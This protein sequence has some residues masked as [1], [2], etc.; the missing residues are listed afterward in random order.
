MLASN[1]TFFNSTDFYLKVYELSPAKVV[2]VLTS[3]FIIFILTPLFYAIIWYEQYSSNH[4][5][6]LIN[7]LVASS[8]WHTIAYNTIGQ[9][10]EVVLSLFGPFNRVFCNVQMVLKNISNLQ[11]INLLLAMTVVKYLSI[12]VLKNPTGIEADFWNF[13][14]T[15]ASFLCRD[16]FSKHLSPAIIHP[17]LFLLEGLD[18]I[19]KDC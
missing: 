3:A 14:I 19:S 11:Q 18:R 4:Y 13:F 7:K 8:C 1:E 6:T 16:S 10:A 5:R 12:F 9:T 15:S 17:E 2:A